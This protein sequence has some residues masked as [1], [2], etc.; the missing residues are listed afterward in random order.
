[1]P[2]ILTL[3]DSILIHTPI[4]RCFALFTSVEIIEQELRGDAV[5]I[6]PDI[7]PC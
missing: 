4:E 5:V 7:A 1:M 2:P 6:K 3:H